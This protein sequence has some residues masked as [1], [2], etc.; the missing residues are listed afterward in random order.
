MSNRPSG[1]DQN[2]TLR[3]MVLMTDGENCCGLR[4]TPVAQNENALAVC[5]DLRDEAVVVFSIAFEAPENG[6]NL[7]EECAS[8]ESHFFNTNG[9]GMRATFQAI[10][11]QINALSLR[12]TI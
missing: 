11:R 6:V 2:D 9:E 12:L 3:I 10:G 7:M 4:D 8:S 5:E 1:F